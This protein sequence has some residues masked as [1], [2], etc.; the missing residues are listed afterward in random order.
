MADDL[1]LEWEGRGLE[2][3]VAWCP[4][5]VSDRA[6]ILKEVRRLGFDVRNEDALVV[7]HHCVGSVD[8]DDI[9]DVCD[10]FGA[11][12][13]QSAERSFVDRDSIFWATFVFLT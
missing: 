8:E 13:A 3:A 6:V 9:P 4:G 7:E 5:V 12:V 10:I 2:D 1:W 11:T